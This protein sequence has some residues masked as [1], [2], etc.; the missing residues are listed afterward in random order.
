MEADPMRVRDIAGSN[1]KY[2]SFYR[3]CISIP[4]FISFSLIFF[5]IFYISPRGE[6]L[7]LFQKDVYEWNKDHLADHMNSL[8]FR[9]Q[10]VPYETAAGDSPL[11]LE[12]T[13]Q[14]ANM[15]KEASGTDLEIE[16][17]AKQIYY[18]H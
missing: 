15:L 10:I 7:H 6:S 12:H 8:E 4:V 11:N 18:Y 17:T 2:E 14:D 16:Q 5:M 3:V 9:Y 1:E 13:E